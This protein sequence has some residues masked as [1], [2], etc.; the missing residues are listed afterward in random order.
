MLARRIHLVVPQGAQ[1]GDNFFEPRE[2]SPYRTWTRP[3]K[4]TIGVVS[5]IAAVS[6]I[7]VAFLLIRAYRRKRLGPDGKR[8]LDEPELGEQKTEDALDTAELNTTQRN[9]L[10]G[11][12][13]VP[14]E[15]DGTD[16]SRLARHG[17]D[18]DANYMQ[19]QQTHR[20]RRAS[21]S[22]VERSASTMSS[23]LPPYAEAL[24]AA[25]IDWNFVEVK[26]HG[27]SAEDIEAELNQLRNRQF[28]LENRLAHKKKAE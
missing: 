25:R 8:K 13:T 28:E 4:I 23:H 14:V 1:Y 9:E 5:A 24:Q 6:L 12:T 26:R 11:S 16:A 22:M 18:R 17:W 20:R 15:L 10:N 3:A 27:E 7:T 21:M 2:Q 19:L